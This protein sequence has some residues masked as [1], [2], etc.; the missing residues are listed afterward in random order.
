MS[1][2]S[3]G[4]IFSPAVAGMQR[5]TDRVSS[6]AN[7][8]VNGQLDPKPIVDMKLGQIGFTADVKVAQTAEEMSKTLLDIFA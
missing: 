1:I 2:G 8:I 6:D 7:A 4:S 3:I 5:E